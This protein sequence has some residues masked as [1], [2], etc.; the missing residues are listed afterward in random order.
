MPVV[1]RGDHVLIEVVQVP[2]KPAARFTPAKPGRTDYVV[3]GK[4][5][6]VPA[7][8]AI[9]SRVILFQPKSEDYVP[10]RPGFLLV[11]ESQIV[12]GLTGEDD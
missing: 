9:G 4:G 6:G 8:V 7:Q 2:P 5:P 10:A 3:R 12:A 1:L 11:R